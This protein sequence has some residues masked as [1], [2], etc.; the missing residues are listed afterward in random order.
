MSKKTAPHVYTQNTEDKQ[1]IVKHLNEIKASL[2]NLD[3]KNIKKIYDDIE[4]T[5][6]NIIY[7]FVE[8]CY[9]RNIVKVTHLW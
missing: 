2:R 4:I 5:N 7:E 6:Y 9:G 1:I 3:L 8:I